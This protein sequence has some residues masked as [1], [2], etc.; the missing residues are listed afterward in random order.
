MSILI[1]LTFKLFY[2]KLN[3]LK[4]LSYFVDLY[5]MMWYTFIEEC[6]IRLY[7]EMIFMKKYLIGQIIR[8]EVEE[9]YTK[10]INDVK[11]YHKGCRYNHQVAVECYL[12]YK[13][14]CNSKPLSQFMYV[15]FR[16]A[17]K[18]YKINKNNY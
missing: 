3:E 9:E 6:T 11:Y 8:K 5:L 12:I 7:K 16:I 14:A 18:F 13:N 2:N 1:V 17:D 15:Y 10:V 4:K